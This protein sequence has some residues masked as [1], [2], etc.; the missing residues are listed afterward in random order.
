M[1]AL[2][3]FELID[4]SFPHI[5]HGGDYNPEQWIETPEI[6]NED[7]R[8]MKKAHCNEMTVGIFSWAEIE[9][10]EGVFDFSWLDEI[11]DK[12]YSEGGRV[13]LATPS[14]A[15]PRWMGIKYPEVLRVIEDGRRI[16]IKN[17]HN[18]C[19]TSPV[20]R[21]KVRIINEKLAQ[22]YGNNP[23]VA[24]WHISNEYNGGCYCELCQ[25]KFREWL[26][27]RYEN[28]IDK[29][30]HAW[31]ARFWSH[32]Y[33]N[34]EEITAPINTEEVDTPALNLDWKRFISDMT[35]DFAKKEAEA[36]RKYSDKPITT[37]CMC[38]FSGY[39]HYKMAE[40]LDRTS[41][42]YYPQWHNGVSTEGVRLAYL[43]SLY[44][45]MKG[46][47]PFMIMESAPGTFAAAMTFGKIKSTETQIMEAIGCVANGAD[48]IGY[49]QWRKGQ[50]GYEKLH[51]AIVD[52]YGKE[53]SRVFGAIG[54]IGEYLEKLSPVLGTGIESEVAIVHDYETIWALDGV[55]NLTW[56]PGKNGYIQTSKL[57][58]QGFCRK[59]IPADII[60]YSEDFS[61]YKVLCLNVPYLMDEKLAEKI[62]AYVENGGILI[63]TYLTAVSDKTDLCYLGGVPALGLSEVFGLRVDEVDNYENAKDKNSVTYNGKEYAVNNIAE[64]IKANDAEILATYN[65][66]FYKGTP[67]VLKHKYG[68]GTAY[69]IGFT[70][71]WDAF[72]EDFISDI[73][74]EYAIKP[75]EGIT[76]DRYVHVT[77]RSGDGEKYYFVINY[78]DEEKT[79]TLSKELYNMLE[80]KSESGKL[81]IEPRGVRV[82]TEK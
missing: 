42:D 75:V 56:F 54:K 4:K 10:E 61:K 52:H 47:K 71:A 29:L 80:D 32:R 16:G 78:S 67:A 51:G 25:N 68:K 23:A 1:I 20:Y 81:T 49:F 31:W 76:A 7:M 74:K 36:I 5:L 3:K 70:P 39:D 55:R 33:N 69:Y 8:L 58:Y 17:R 27:D 40:V 9:K 65:S 21:E 19:Y 46:G 22:R 13:I 12:V 45:G 59:N 66:D 62:K 38:E 11:I 53:D 43:A 77:M 26:R 79:F 28:D 15:R 2:K 63:S 48:M 50:G 72:T 82:Y 57:L 44:R 41:Y 60:P 24:A 37:N 30:N 35:V 73:T 18:H 34:F 14:G 64:V 6:W